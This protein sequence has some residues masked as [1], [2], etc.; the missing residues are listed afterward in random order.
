[1]KNIAIIIPVYNEE[2]NIIQLC[3]TLNTHLNKISTIVFDYIYVNNGSTDKTREKLDILY[4]KEDK[5]KVIN[6][7]RN[8]GKEN[9]MLA[10]L[11]YVSDKYDAAI[12]VD[13]DLETPP[14]YI[15]EMVEKWLEG[16]K[17]VLTYRN[18]RDKKIIDNIAK[19][20]YKVYN[21]FVSNKINNDALDFQLMDKDI[22]NVY[23]NMPE[24]TRFLKGI[25]AFIGYKTYTIPVDMNKRSHGKSKFSGFKNLFLY[26]LDGLF[27]NT[28]IPLKLSMILGTILMFVGTINTI[29][30]LIIPQ[31]ATILNVVLTINL[32]FGGII[33]FILGIIGYYLSLVYLEV[34]QRP[35]FIID[36]KKE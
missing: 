35:K 21:N 33:I 15:N 23:I 20:Y 16:Y 34:Q 22:I 3:E 13:G 2:K 12:I 10:G 5:V 6:L 24:Q 25:T 7:S 31:K 26:G 9:S 32:I 8:F 1:M 28:V 29:I 14:E 30:Q 4:K 36:E 11:T 17:L 19:M 18:N 27:S